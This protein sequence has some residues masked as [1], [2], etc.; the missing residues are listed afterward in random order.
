MAC[1]FIMEKSNFTM[2]GMF[3]F[4]KISY[5]KYWQGCGE[6]RPITYMFS[7]T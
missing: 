6:R 1:N 2:V 7:V 4:E 3:F 5:E